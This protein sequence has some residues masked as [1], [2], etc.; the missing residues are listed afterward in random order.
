MM[1]WSYLYLTIPPVVVVVG[2][3]LGARLVRQSTDR[4]DRM[5]WQFDR[6]AAVRSQIKGQIP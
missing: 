4:V 2:A 1:E 5:Q 6:E 3:V